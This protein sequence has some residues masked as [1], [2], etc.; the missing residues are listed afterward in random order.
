[1]GDKLFDMEV[2]P[3]PALELK[4]RIK[5][6]QSEMSKREID[7]AL[8]SGLANKYYFG[9]IVQQ[10]MIYIDRE[11]EAVYLVRSGVERAKY[12]S[13]LDNVV[14]FA[15]YSDIPRILNDLGYAIPGK[16]GFESD[17]VPVAVFERLKK[18]LG[19][20]D[21]CDI[22]ESVLF[23]RMIKSDYEVQ[24]IRKAA[25]VVDAGI[26]K[27]PEML[28]EGMTELELQAKI[29]Y[30]MRLMGHPGGVRSHGWDQEFGVGAVLSGENGVI[31][32]YMAAVLGG[33]GLS[34]GMPAGPSTRKIKKNEP[35]IVDMVGCWNGYYADMSRTFCMGELPEVALTGYQW[36]K[37]LQ[38]DIVSQMA[39]G[40]PFSELTEWIFNKA[41]EAGYGENFMGIGDAKVSFVGH[42]V[43]LELDDYPVVFRRWKG[44]AIPGQ[45]IA[46]EPKLMFPGIG[47]VGVENTWLVKEKAAD[48]KL[49]C[50]TNTGYEL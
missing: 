30:E 13:P 22:S 38:H 46:I 44:S 23:A 28:R 1:M 31:G 25:R 2:E 26:V 20:I 3:L 37:D 9:G 29:E 10:G 5:M 39:K 15:R 24:Q 50:I 8:I 12:V 6:L 17:R 7:G 42:G 41:D 16:L 19:G 27:V 45:I 21:F 18:T 36:C 47:A 4:S 35:V 43:G 40:L 11:G 33:K 49:E 48:R 34:N 32:N 14:S